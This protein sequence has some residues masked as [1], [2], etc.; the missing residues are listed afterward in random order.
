MKIAGIK[1]YFM[2]QLI[3]KL[4]DD[5]EKLVR[6]AYEMRT[7][8]NRTYNLHDSYGSAVYVDGRLIKSSVRYAGSPIA[9]AGK[10]YEDELIEGRFEIDAFFDWFKP[11]KKGVD[12]VVIAT[13]PYADILEKGAGL[14]RKYKVNA[15]G[16][17]YMKDVARRFRGTLSKFVKPRD[18]SAMTTIKDKSWAQ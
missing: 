3:Q 15:E 4:T 12:L 18:L 8:E 10:V 1:D 16:E 17:D 2:N 13:M 14:R 11:H 5:G 7:F 9:K 6:H